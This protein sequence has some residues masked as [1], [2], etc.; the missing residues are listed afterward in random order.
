[1]F[2]FGKYA[3]PKGPYQKYQDPLSYVSSSVANKGSVATASKKT[4]IQSNYTPTL[5]GTDPN[6]SFTSGGANIGGGNGGYNSDRYNPVFDNLEEGTILEDWI[7]RDAAGLD[8]LYRRIYLRDPTLGPGIDIIRNLPWSDFTLEGIEDN[9]IKKIYEE[10][11]SSLN[12]M[13][14]MPDITHEFLVLGRSI[15]SLIF[16]HKRGIFSGVVPHDPDFVRIT[17]VPVYGFDPMC[18]FTLSPGFKKFLQ[19]QD[20][21]AVDARKSL[22]PSFLEAAANQQGFLPLDPIS[23]I[24]LS[25][26]AAPN[27]S[28]GTSILT[29]TLYFW[30]IEKALLNAQLSSTRR[31]ARS[32]IHLKA[33]IDNMWE[34]SP[35]EIDA[36]AGIV[37]QANEDPVGGVIATR[38]GVE[39]SEPVSGGADFYKWSDELELFA[40][41]KMQCIGISD[42][43][44]SGDA[45]YANADQARSVFVENLASLRSRIVNKFF[46]QKLFPVVARVHGFV[47]RTPAELSHRI[48][49][50]SAFDGPRFPSWA[51]TTMITSEKLTQRKVMSLPIENLMIP[52][53]N[54]AKQLK[55]TQDEKAL[56]ILE[57]LKQNEYPVTLS[58]WASA[59]GLNPKTIEQEQKD[60]LD[61]QNRIQKLQEAMA[62]QEAETSDSGEDLGMDI[63]EASDEQPAGEEAPA[64]EPVQQ[65]VYAKAKRIAK[66]GPVA[67]I[68][69][70]AIWNHGK[71]G[72]LS[73]KDAQKVTSSLLKDSNPGI[74][75]DPRA[76][77]NK[78]QDKVGSERAPI[79]AYVLNRLGLTS[80]MIDS[81]SAQVIA[82]SARDNLNRYSSF[83]SEKAMLDVRR[84]ETEIQA[85]SRYAEKMRLNQSQFKA[86][87]APPP[88]ID[89]KVMG[90][91]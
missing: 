15:S 41:Y 23:T 60:N 66:G 49:T 82:K 5:S 24:Y 46:M 13:L 57:R 6:S 80:F 3:T 9:E 86:K 77:L 79:L 18:D 44:L 1:M 27:D 17:P 20:P 12:P 64:E 62:P 67:R 21:R 37:I 88:S 16:D 32:F 81:K 89:S 56:E 75:K 78:L 87:L 65:S 29:R 55:P 83:S 74:F 30:A 7:P 40:K 31:R 51:Q 48:R 36:L 61:L 91:Y 45:T 69:Q 71:C 10:C 68:D 52:T 58:Q 19:S 90:G 35:E 14:L 85:L 76:L 11:M 43:L 84:Y 34:P 26:K 53:I 73:K 33:G 8:L 4:R 2:K 72:G 70:I 59:A 22:P 42:A 28:I 63:P 47:K 25:R 50:T 38:T 54:W 39:I